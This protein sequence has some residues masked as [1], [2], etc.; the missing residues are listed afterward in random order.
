MTTF[1]FLSNIQFVCER[2][3]FWEKKARIRIKKLVKEKGISLR[4]LAR[5][6]D[7]EPAIINKLANN[8]HKSIYLEHIERIANALNITDTNEI[9]EIEEV[10]DSE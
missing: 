8:K 2:V 1:I 3:I 9:I 6:S 4:K 5:L 10:E 7:I